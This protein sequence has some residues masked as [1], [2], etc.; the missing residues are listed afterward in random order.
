MFDFDSAQEVCVSF[1]FEEGEVSCR[2]LEKFFRFVDLCG[3]V[4]AAAAIGVVQQH[5]CAVGLADLFLGDGALTV[6]V[7]IFF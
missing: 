4:R 7:S 2:F 1:Y 5:E 6:V 3:K